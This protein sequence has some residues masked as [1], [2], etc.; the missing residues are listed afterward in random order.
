MKKLLLLISLTGALS[1]LSFTSFI[2]HAEE[3]SIATEQAQDEAQN[4]NE[5]YSNYDDNEESSY[6]ENSDAIS[7]EDM[8]QE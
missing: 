8:N 6:D 1:L 7:D 5:E 4:Y 2:A 3:T